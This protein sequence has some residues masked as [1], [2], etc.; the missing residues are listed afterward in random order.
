MIPRNITD[1]VKVYK[2]FLSKVFCKN[3]IKELENYNW[4]KHQFHTYKDDVVKHSNELSVSWDSSKLKEELNNKIWYVIEQYILKDF[5]NFNDWFCSWN[6][7]S[8]IR[9]NRY[10]EKTEMR[11]HCDHIFSMFDGVRKGIPTL[12]IVGSLNNNYKGGEFI[13]WQ[14]EHIQIPEGA[15]LIFPSNFMYPHKVKPI[16]KGQR[17]SFVSWVY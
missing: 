4:Q 17:Y 6:G 11:E 2:N 10:D 9:F 3:L 7:Y 1:Y 13:M 8:E 14:T 16:K 12:S 15:I 5:A